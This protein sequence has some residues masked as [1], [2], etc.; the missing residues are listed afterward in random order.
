MMVPLVAFH[1]DTTSQ[2]FAWKACA[3]CMSATAGC[4]V[5]LAGPN[6]MRHCALRVVGM[7]HASLAVPLIAS[8]PCHTGAPGQELEC[9]QCIICRMLHV[10]IKYSGWV[11]DKVHS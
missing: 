2:S 3:D 8:N 9:V 6:P 5:L 4:A 11:L 10:R 7:L 1:H